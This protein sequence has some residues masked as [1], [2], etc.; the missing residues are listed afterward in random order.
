MHFR[1]TTEALYAGGDRCRE[2]NRVFDDLF[3]M[4]LEEESGYGT[5]QTN[6]GPAVCD[7]LVAV[8]YEV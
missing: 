2:V 4:L 1:T 6:P 5:D 8:G 7:L 3:M